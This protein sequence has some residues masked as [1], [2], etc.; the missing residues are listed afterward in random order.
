MTRKNFIILLIVV[1]ALVLPT[2]LPSTSDPEPLEVNQEELGEELQT[3]YITWQYPIPPSEK[4]D[5]LNVS[6]GV[7]MDGKTYA[8]QDVFDV[9]GIPKS[10]GSEG[11]VITVDGFTDVYYPLR[12]SAEQF[13][14]SVLWAPNSEQNGEILDHW[15]YIAKENTGTNWVQVVFGENQEK[16]VY[17][18]YR[19]FYAYPD[20]EFWCIDR[21]DET[22][23]FPKANVK[24]ME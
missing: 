1:V 23:R 5:K 3:V 24:I 9:L 19:Y 11:T 18:N 15:V 17:K 12:E 20:G 21:D 6:E 8:T 2:I 7:L 22:E 16:M 10:S 4:G 14:Y 13:D